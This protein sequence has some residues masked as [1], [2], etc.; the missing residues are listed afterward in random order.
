MLYLTWNLTVASG[1]GGAPRR[2]APHNAEYVGT[3]EVVVLRCYPAEKYSSSDSSESASP[4]RPTPQDTRTESERSEPSATAQPEEASSLSSDETASNQDTPAG[5]DLMGD[6][7]DGGCD[8][9]SIKPATTFGLDGS[10]DSPPQAQNN[11]EQW[12]PVMTGPNTGT[13][14]TIGQGSAQHHGGQQRGNRASSERQQPASGPPHMGRRSSRHGSSHTQIAG[15]VSGSRAG[16]ERAHAIPSW[17]VVPATIPENPSN[18]PSIVINLVHPPSQPAISRRASFAGSK[19]SRISEH[20]PTQSI[21]PA[22]KSQW[23]NI[24]PEEKRGTSSSSSANAGANAPGNWGLPV[25]KDNDAIDLVRPRKDSWGSGAAHAPI[26][27]AWQESGTGWGGPTTGCNQ[28]NTWDSGGNGDNAYKNNDKSGNDWDK[29]KHSS[30]DNAG[31]NSWGTVAPNS[32]EA[33]NGNGWDNNATSGAQ[34]GTWDNGNYQRPSNNAPNTGWNDH[35]GSPGGSQKKDGNQG[36]NQVGDSRHSQGN[37]GGQHANQNSNTNG[38]GQ[39][40]A[41]NGGGTGWTWPGQANLPH[42]L[43]ARISHA[44]TGQGNVPGPQAKAPFIPSFKPA[45]PIL[46]LDTTGNQGH[47]RTSQTPSA[48][49]VNPIGTW[50]NNTVTAQQAPVGAGWSSPTLLR[51]GSSAQPVS[52]QHQ[53]HAPSS[54]EDGALYASVNPFAKPYWSKWKDAAEAH[55]LGMYRDLLRSQMPFGAEEPLYV[56]PDEVAQRKCVSHQVQTGKPVPYVHKKSAPKYLDNFNNPYAVFVFHYRSK[57]MFSPTCMR[58]ANKVYRYYRENVECDNHRNGRGGEAETTRIVQGG[59]HRLFD[60]GKSQY[61]Q[62]SIQHCLYGMMSNLHRRQ[63]LLAMPRTQPGQSQRLRQS[64]RTNP[65]SKAKRRWGPLISML[66]TT[67]CRIF[68]QAIKATTTRRRRRETAGLTI[69]RTAAGAITSRTIAGITGTT[70]LETQWL[71]HQTAR[72]Q[73]TAPDR[74][75]APRHKRET[76]GTALSQIVGGITETAFLAMPQLVHKGVE[77]QAAAQGLGGA[78]IV[79]EVIEAELRATV[80]AKAVIRVCG[81]TPAEAIGS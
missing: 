21:E 62:I 25:D 39:G 30:P 48:R 65:I 16:S 79:L 81:I 33:A 73:A 42:P 72:I 3:I 77:I 45:V 27:G 35:D 26:P 70:H 15:G 10:W 52:T 32:P 75:V 36:W 6:L 9:R 55:D 57:G 74:G 50:L 8:D 60:G 46:N 29:E 66:S 11:Q 58:L 28:P 17:D 20:L 63:R 2:Q 12:G 59:D 53:D 61:P 19:H 78:K 68:K 7:F 5:G 67:S 64:V 43:S 13:Y 22:Q 38:Q 31:D 37:N 41:G 51:Q 34:Q 80:M 69:S 47:W 56:V 14:Q 54:L 24:S 76:T 23:Q 49:Q 40:W 18:A 44:N 71:D 4:M 1:N